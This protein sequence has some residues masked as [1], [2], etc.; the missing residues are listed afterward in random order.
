MAD[1]LDHNAE[2]REAVL[3]AVRKALG[4]GGPDASAGER[5]RAHL[6][7]PAQGPRPRLPDDLVGRFVAR[8]LEMSSTV[9]RIPALADVPRAVARYLDALELPPALAGQKSHAG[10]CWP[11]LAQLDWTGAGLAVEA[12]PARGSDALGITG[13]FCAV[14]E[15][16]TLA[17]TASAA[18][19]TVS[20]L[21]PATH[22]CVLRP[23]QVVAGL[24][25][26]SAR[27]RSEHAAMPRA[28]N[29]VSGPSRTGDIEQTIVLGA[30]GPFRVHIL[31]V[32]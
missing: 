11:E 26:A 2:A 30:H 31:L 21:L 6:A 32:A 27:V 5:A 14:A 16:G 4:R 25:E 1:A 10:V 7:A 15:T 29:F 17:F 23:A 28:V 18:T 12:R 22:V 19:P 9:E 20:M 3:G 24:E 13:C 8:A